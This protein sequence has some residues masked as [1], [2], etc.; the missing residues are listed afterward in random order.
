MA[1]LKDTG[2]VPVP[3]AFSFYPLAKRSLE[4]AEKKGEGMMMRLSRFPGKKRTTP[5]GRNHTPPI[6]DEF[7]QPP[8]PRPIVGRRPES[9]SV[10]IHS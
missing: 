6:M 3:F 10:A 9:S 7:S 2:E 5:A 8:T 4:R 1:L